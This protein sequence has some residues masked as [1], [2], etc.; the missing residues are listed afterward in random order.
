MFRFMNLGVVSPSTSNQ[1][2][3]NVVSSVITDEKEARLASNYTQQM[4]L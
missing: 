2:C 1:L 4:A 3:K